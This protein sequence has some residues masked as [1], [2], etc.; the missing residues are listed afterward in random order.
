MGLLFGK[1]TLKMFD[2]DVAELEPELGDFDVKDVVIVAISL[3]G[4]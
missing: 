3:V 4:S 2:V 1:H